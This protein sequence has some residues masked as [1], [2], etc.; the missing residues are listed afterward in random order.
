MQ[1]ELDMMLQQGRRNAYEKILRE[2]HDRK[3]QVDNDLIVQ[4][5]EWANQG[6]HKLSPRKRIGKI[7]LLGQEYSD[8]E[9]EIEDEEEERVSNEQ[10][11]TGGV[12]VPYSPSN[13][14]QIKREVNY[15]NGYGYNDDMTYLDSKLQQRWN[16]KI[17]HE[18]QIE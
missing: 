15:K 14:K 4:A 18:L 16:E 1:Q 10:H 17:E 8:P 11:Y 9:S 5:Q 7:K 2:E 13:S 12:E 3:E 6:K